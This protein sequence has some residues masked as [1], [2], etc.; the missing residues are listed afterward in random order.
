MRRALQRP[1]IEEIPGLQP[2]AG[3]RLRCVGMCGSGCGRP[4]D[5]PGA[6]DERY[7]RMNR[8]RTERAVRMA[9]AWVM[10]RTLPGGRLLTGRWRLRGSRSAVGSRMDQAISSFTT[11]ARSAPTS[12]KL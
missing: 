11:L 5:E 1:R 9:T 3:R 4:R 8:N 7:G 12:L 10:H 6:D 2:Y